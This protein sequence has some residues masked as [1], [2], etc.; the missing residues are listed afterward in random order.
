MV[1]KRASLSVL[2]TSVSVHQPR[3]LDAR[4]GRFE[5]ACL[6]LLRGVLPPARDNQ[7]AA[8]FLRRTIGPAHRSL[9]WV[10]VRPDSLQEGD[11]CEHALHEGLVDSLFSP[12][13][14][15]MANVARVIAELVTAPSTWAAWR[16]KL[17]VVVDVVPRA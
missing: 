16:G 17:P 13:H 4:R 15:R 5:R 6:W 2:M 1:T 8:D 7:R 14:T 11:V 3:P 10:V 12:G 9:E